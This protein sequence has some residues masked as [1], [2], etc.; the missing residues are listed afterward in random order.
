MVET[1]IDLQW[2]TKEKQL[3]DVHLTF[4]M[5]TVRYLPYRSMVPSAIEGLLIQIEFHCEGV[6]TAAKYLLA[7]GGHDC[8]VLT[9][10]M[11][12]WTLESVEKLLRFIVGMH[13]RERKSLKN[14]L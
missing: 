9:C 8:R 2:T 4:P 11:K 3:F 1:L 13:D 5:Q 7:I 10:A 6:P 12:L 14:E